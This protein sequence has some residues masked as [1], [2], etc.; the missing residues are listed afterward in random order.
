MAVPSEPSELGE[1]GATGR[2]QRTY[3]PGAAAVDAGADAGGGIADADADVPEEG[4]AEPWLGG[5]MSR[6]S[7]RLGGDY[8]L[9]S[10]R[11][12]RAVQRARL[13]AIT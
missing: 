12:S 2:R 11:P 10:P 9:S 5:A 3:C 1:A 4:A 8:P 13:C 6:A 7:N